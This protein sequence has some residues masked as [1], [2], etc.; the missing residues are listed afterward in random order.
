MCTVNAVTEILIYCQ[1]SRAVARARAQKPA[2]GASCRA[3]PLGGAGL[4][5]ANDR[6]IV[7][8]RFNSTE[9]NR[10]DGRVVESV[11]LFAFQP[12]G[13]SWV[14]DRVVGL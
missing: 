6:Y 7:N 1:G 13:R 8:R 9:A 11:S 14:R 4:S 12:D 5:P 2:D 3:I 10:A